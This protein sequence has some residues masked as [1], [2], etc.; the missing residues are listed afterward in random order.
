MPNT[1][2]LLETI[3]VGAA[4]ATS[5]TFN[6]IPQTGYTDLVIKVSGRSN[7][8]GGG[9]GGVWDAAFVK[10]NGSSTSFSNRYLFGAGS[11]A[12]GSGIG[13][14]TSIDFWTDY[15]GA[16]ASTFGSTEIYIPNYTSSNFKSVSVDTVAEN[17]GTAGFNG[18]N[19]GL[20]SNTAAITSIALSPASGSWVQY[21]TFSL[22]G[23]SA[24]GTT[25]TR[26]PKATGGSIIQTDGTYW[27]HAFLSSGTFTPAT[28]LTCDVLVVGGGGGGGCQIGGGGGAGGIFYA[29]S[30][31]IGVSAQTV[32][33]GAGGTGG[34]FS[35]TKGVSGSNSSFASLTAGVGGGGGGSLLAGTGVDGVSGGSGGGGG[36]NGTGNGTGGSST[37]TGTGGTGYGFGGGNGVHPAGGGGGGASAAGSN[38]ASSNG[39]TG[40]A[41]LNTWSSWLS[42][43]GLGVSGFIAGGG[44]GGSNNTVAIAGGS[45]GGG[46]G[47]GGTTIAPVAGTANTGSGGGG[48]RDLP[49]SGESG[50]R[51]GSGLVIIRYLAA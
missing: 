16:T 15:S 27:Y 22:Y 17:N 12:P 46:A 39:G 33:I 19:A 6:S 13:S 20:W 44:G 36:T 38:A 41:G 25:P 26:A 4:G 7:A 42:T 31:A 50:G 18:F 10:F 51:G 49:S 23:V 48:S 2:T 47:G 5:V 8:S 34:V 3:T 21:S 35:N 1:Y 11:G 14:T 43:T 40:G 9:G 32:T 45:G 24:L 37:Q 28:A 30:Q 29:T